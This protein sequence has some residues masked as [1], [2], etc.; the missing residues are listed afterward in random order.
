MKED[1]QPQ[2]A[3]EATGYIAGVCY[4]MARAVLRDHFTVLLLVTIG[5]VCWTLF[6][7]TALLQT[8]G[9]Y[10][11]TTALILGHALLRKPSA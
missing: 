11:A 5:F 1:T 3:I 4:G 6:V 8:L 2:T 7:G 9:L 10:I